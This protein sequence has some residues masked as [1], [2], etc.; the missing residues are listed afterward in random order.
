MMLSMRNSSPDKDNS[1]GRIDN[2]PSTKEFNYSS[3]VKSPYAYRLYCIQYSSQIVPV[4]YLDT[5]DLKNWVS[6]NTGQCW[7]S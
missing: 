5:T 6:I 7:I 4:I 3:L 2:T 1:D